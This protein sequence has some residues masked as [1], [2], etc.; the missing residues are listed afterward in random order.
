VHVVTSTTLF[1]QYLSWVG[2][3]RMSMSDAVV[4]LNKIKKEEGPH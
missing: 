1:C 2:D 4:T 3:Q